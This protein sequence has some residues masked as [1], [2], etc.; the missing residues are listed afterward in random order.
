[1]ENRGE[2]GEEEE[3]LE[4]ESLSVNGQRNEKN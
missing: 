2:G 4:R 3:T 1:M